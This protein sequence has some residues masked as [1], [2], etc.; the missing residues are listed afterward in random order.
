[1]KIT[2]LNLKAQQVRRLALRY[3]KEASS[4]HPGGC[5]SAAEILVSLYFN[6]ALPQPYHPAAA[7]RD[8]IILS[9]GHSAPALYACWQLLIDSGLPQPDWWGAG[10]ETLRKVG[11]AFQGHPAL[12][13][14]PWCETS[15]GSL[16]QGLA[17][18]AGMAL[19][20]RKKGRR[21]YVIAGDGELEEG[22][23]AE[24]ARLASFYRLHNLTVIVDRNGLSSDRCSI[25]VSRPNLE[26]A[27]YGWDV[28]ECDGH[29]VADIDK[30]V[31]RSWQVKSKPTLIMAY[32]V[33]GKG[34]RRA[35]KDLD[36]MHGS[37]MLSDKDLAEAE[38]EWLE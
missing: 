7:D 1:M 29:N 16:G 22:I 25:M 30:V 32:T 36:R 20:L 34:W 28:A 23:V 5:L 11:S 19:A 13:H 4:G 24:T 38:S 6:L 27:A 2:E 17:V 35:E 14:T 37:V 12:K 8:I 9:K 10:P 21:V 31:R 3:I 18:G 26:F 15:T 33:K